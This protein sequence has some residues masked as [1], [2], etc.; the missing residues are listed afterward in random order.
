M[1]LKLIQRY[2]W[3]VGFFVVGMTLFGQGVEFTKDDFILSGDATSGDS[4]CFQ[5]TEDTYWQSGGVW[6]RNKIDLNEPFS[7][8]LEISFGCNDLF[9]ADGM[10]FIFNPYPYSGRA[11]EGM[12][13]GRL[14]PSFGIEMDTYEN[15]HLADPSYDHVAFMQNGS[16]RHYEAI[17]GPVPLSN[18]SSNVE[19]C[20]PH[21]V[22]VEWAPESKE[23]AFYFDGSLRLK[24]QVDL[25]KDIFFDDPEVYWGF[26]SATGQKFNKQ[27]VCVKSLEYSEKFR[28]DTRSKL[29][30]LNETY[31]L[32]NLNFPTGSSVLP[33]RGKSELKQLIRFFNRHPTHSIMIEGFTD[34]QGAEGQ[35]ENISEERAKSV[36]DFLK[37]NGI[38]AERVRYYGRGE[39]NPIAPNNTKEGRAKNRRIEVSL[40]V[41]R[42]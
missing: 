34:S 12:G 2:C 14:Y 40:G 20:K 41:N 24:K 33:Q 22:K 1:T 7:M 39:K 16:L 30:L 27:M 5:L 35:N 9:G 11:G 42:V 38:D 18:T 23:M 31:T 15:Y 4:N 29:K 32:K 6:F 17:T 28:L 36:A 21:K 37:A 13:F 10:V 8:E 19:D 25:V 26:S 3:F